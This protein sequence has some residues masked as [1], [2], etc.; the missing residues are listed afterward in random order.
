MSIFYVFQFTGFDKDSSGDPFSSLLPNDHGDTVGQDNH[1]TT[2]KSA[3]TST[4]TTIK[5]LD[6]TK[7]NAGITPSNEILVDDGTDF[8]DFFGVSENS[9][10]VKTTDVTSTIPTN[11]GNANA[12]KYLMEKK[13]Q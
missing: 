7:N 1:V 2:Q 13:S 8:G 12:G 10:V 5:N 4:L 3:L 6:T 9:K 11:K